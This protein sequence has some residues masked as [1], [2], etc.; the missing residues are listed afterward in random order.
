MNRQRKLKITP[1]FH[2]GQK[3]R[4]RI[5]LYCLLSSI[6]CLFVFAIPPIAAI[7][8]GLNNNSS[9]PIILKDVSIL[10][11]EN[12]SDNPVAT[13]TITELIKKELR[14]KGL[15]FITMDGA[16]EEFLAKRRIRYTGGVTRLAVREMGKVLGVN[17]VLVGSI[18]FYRREADRTGWQRKRP[19]LLLR[20]LETDNG[21]RGQVLFLPKEDR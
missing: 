13:K 19:A 8:N 3:S 21:D 17:A 14:G 7:G 5:F 1:V 20:L 15:V 11:F 12:L 6:S 16:V 10:P 18:G 2:A 9:Q 4:I